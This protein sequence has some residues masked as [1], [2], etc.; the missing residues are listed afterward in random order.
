MSKKTTEPMLKC[1]LVVSPILQYWIALQLF[2]AAGA[3]KLSI[4]IALIYWPVFAFG[5]TG[6]LMAWIMFRTGDCWCKWW[7]IG[8][9]ALECLVLF[10]VK[11]FVME[12]RSRFETTLRNRIDSGKLAEFYEVAH[13]EM[14][15]ISKSIENSRIDGLAIRPWINSMHYGDYT[16]MASKD[17]SNWRVTVSWGGPTWRWGITTTGAPSLLSP[18]GEDKTWVWFQ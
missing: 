8:I 12:T 6:V 16:L 7:V 9:G 14:T 2:S 11:P 5:I 1:A 10:T 3:G 15:Q 17:G 13:H 18:S 4:T